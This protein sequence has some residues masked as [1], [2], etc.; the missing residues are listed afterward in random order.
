ML[1]APAPHTISTRYF[2]NISWS[3]SRND[4]LEKCF[5]ID[6]V[7]VVF[8]FCFIPT[9]KELK[10]RWD[11]KY[12]AVI[13]Q[14]S[15][16]WFYLCCCARCLLAN[17]RGCFYTW[18]AVRNELTKVSKLLLEE[19]WRNFPPNSWA[20]RRAKMEMN[21]NRSNSKLLME[22]MLPSKEFTNSDI[23]LQYLQRKLFK[24]FDEVV[25]F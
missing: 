6:E 16:D 21:S 15:Y 20:P 9:N 3:N 25:H 24:I 7:V 18:K 19:G 10:I 12:D 13:L 23:D 22:D 5:W 11:W 1:T 4:T 8:W 2:M 14:I 17:V